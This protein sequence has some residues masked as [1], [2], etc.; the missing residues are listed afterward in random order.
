MNM[1]TLSC[2]EEH[3]RCFTEKQ[4]TAEI[5]TTLTLCYHNKQTEELSKMIRN[6]IVLVVCANHR[7]GVEEPNIDE[8]HERRKKAAMAHFGS[9]EVFYEPEKS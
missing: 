9:E 5:P 3:G 2:S 4:S 1:N 6:R 8:T 7:D